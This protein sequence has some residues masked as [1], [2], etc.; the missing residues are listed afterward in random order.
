MR[1]PSH[2]MM[3]VTATARTQQSAAVTRP[4]AH[5][6]T[7][8]T[9]QLV[10]TL[11][12]SLTF[13]VDRQFHCRTDTALL[14][15]FYPSWY[16]HEY[17]VTPPRP[18]LN[19]SR[20]M[21]SS[22]LLWPRHGQC[23]AVGPGSNEIRLQWSASTSQHQPSIPRCSVSYGTRH[24]LHPLVDTLTVMLVL[25]GFHLLSSFTQTCLFNLLL[26]RGRDTVLIVGFR[27][28]WMQSQFVWMSV[29]GDGLSLWWWLWTVEL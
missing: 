1:G 26:P 20:I 2:V 18:R 22:G 14:C 16:V 23:T 25:L 8:T 12:G 15:L 6:I 10:C 29:G 7:Q 13:E 4:S 9:W 11:R 5:I 17:R 24:T 28:I 21:T 27:I 3:K 19:Y